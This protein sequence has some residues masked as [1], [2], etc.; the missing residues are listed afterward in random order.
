M[1]KTLDP[2][3]DPT[4]NPSNS[5]ELD[6]NLKKILLDGLTNYVARNKLLGTVV[7]ESVTLIKQAVV[8]S[9]DEMIQSP[10][11]Q[12]GL[13]KAGYRQIQFYNAA[14]VGSDADRR[15]NEAVNPKA[16]PQGPHK[17][18]TKEQ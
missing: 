12:E 5:G 7:E 8:D 11:F 6:R 10:E 4:L 1:K 18:T 9:L 17:L 15:A 3:L 13:S 2:S 14:E 16:S